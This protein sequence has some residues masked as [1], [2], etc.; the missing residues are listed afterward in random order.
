MM[1]NKYRE[2]KVSITCIHC[3]KHKKCIN[4]KIGYICDN[5]LAMLLKN[6]TQN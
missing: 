4:S 1:K 5:C 3:N 6:E 2:M